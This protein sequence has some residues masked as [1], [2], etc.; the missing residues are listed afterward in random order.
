MYECG[1]SKT[2][3]L[4][5]VSLFD[6][7]VYECMSFNTPFLFVLGIV[8]PKMNISVIIFSPLYQCII[9]YKLIYF[10]TLPLYIV[11]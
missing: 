8:H 3:P 7:Y 10:K 5:H 4:L 11:Q 1:F 2:H 9:S 6:M